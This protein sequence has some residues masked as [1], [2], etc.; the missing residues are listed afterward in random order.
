MHVGEHAGPKVNTV[1]QWPPHS[2]WELITHPAHTA[3]TTASP[4]PP[5]SAS[6]TS[7]H[8]LPSVSTRPPLSQPGW[9]PSTA[10]GKELQPGGQ[11][12]QD[13][14]FT[15]HRAGW[16]PAGTCFDGLPS[17]A[18]HPPKRNRT[19]K[20]RLTTHQLQGALGL[21][22]LRRHYPLAASITTHLCFLFCDH[23]FFQLSW[24]N[25][26]GAEFNLDHDERDKPTPRHY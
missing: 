9:H 19:H 1:C 5:P 8:H 18:L 16:S 26:C 3:R 10:P 22:N 12:I 15:T 24:C 7:S 21:T 14:P 6:S 20:P 2:H 4:A 17:P 11:P 13:L 23:S 25:M